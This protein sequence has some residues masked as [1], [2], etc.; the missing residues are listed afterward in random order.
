LNLRKMVPP[1]L[2]LL[3]ALPLLLSSC[4]LFAPSSYRFVVNG[5]EVTKPAV[6][7]TRQKE[8]YVPAS[9]LKQNLGMDVTWTPDA[10]P[11]EPSAKGVYYTDRVQTLMYHDIWPKAQPGRSSITVADFRRQMEL[12]KENGFHVIT[13]DQYADF[14]L[15]KGKIPDNAVLLTFDD[16]YETFYTYAYPILKEFGY[17]ATNFLIVS[18]VD[19]P[20]KPGSPKLRWDQIKR[21]RQDGMSFYS[22]TY[23]QHYT[24]PVNA[25]G[26]QKPALM[27]SQYLP[28]E[29]RMETPEEYRD[30]ITKDLTK[31]EERL[32][33]ELGNKRSI[34]CFPYGKYSLTTLEA[35]KTTG[36]Q[37]MFTTMEGI[38]TRADRISFRMNGSLAGE[39][40]ETLIERM[41]QG[42]KT[43]ENKE[44]KGFLVVNGFDL[45]LSGLVPEM[46]GTELMVPLREFCD[47]AHIG[48]T[49][50]KRSR[51]IEITTL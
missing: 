44:T 40:P 13:M 8:L 5:S 2:L 46:K 21:M 24:V 43:L 34:L 23:D 26:K 18:S 50:D 47:A 20:K 1:S 41:K 30:R 45:P 14:I 31:A 27:H 48:L 6:L 11:A 32:K 36:I 42:D 22:H 10:Q 7:E 29:Q 49:L 19:N 3:L 35:A 4:G 51:R 33:A 25:E 39:K 37:L 17:T 9:F 28:K 15:N 12:L 16:G 38:D